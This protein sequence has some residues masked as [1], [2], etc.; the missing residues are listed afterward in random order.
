VLKRIRE[1][2]ADKAAFGII[3]DDK[4]VTNFNAFS[5]LKRHSDHL[6]IYKHADKPHFI[7]KIG[8][9]VEDFIFHCAEQCNISLVDYDLPTDL[10]QLKNRTKQATS[11]KDNNLKRL[12]LTLKQN[13][14]S[15]F[16]KLAQWIELFKA[17]PYSITDKLL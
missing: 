4:T 2:F 5:L 8:K 9:A 11:L 3:D 7:V 15:D 14:S 16:C 12:F 17:N 1:K 6:A 10:N 13:N